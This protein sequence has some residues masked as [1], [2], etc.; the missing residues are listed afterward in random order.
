MLD[1]LKKLCRAIL[2]IDLSPVRGRAKFNRLGRAIADVHYFVVVTPM[3]DDEIKA[4]QD[5]LMKVME[6][7]T[8]SA[9]KLQKAI[10]AVG[11]NC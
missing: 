9:W 4:A 2:Q 1:E 8:S 7:M 10:D 5:H 3:D 11:A 6:Q